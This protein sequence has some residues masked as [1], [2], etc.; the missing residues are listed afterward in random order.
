MADLIINILIMIVFI[1][2]PLSGFLLLVWAVKNNPSKAY[3]R[4]YYRTR[5][6]YCV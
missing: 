6:K 4:A 3:W 5:D 1:S 2:F